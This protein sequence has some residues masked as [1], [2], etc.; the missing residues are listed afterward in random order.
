M[1]VDDEVMAV[2]AID[3]ANPNEG[4]EEER[5]QNNLRYGQLNRFGSCEIN[6]T[7][8][9]EKSH[10]I[11]DRKHGSHDRETFHCVQ[12]FSCIF[13]VSVSFQLEVNGVLGDPDLLGAISH[14]FEYVLRLGINPLT[15][16]LHFHSNLL[17]A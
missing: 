5:E 14:L 17:N 3:T 2:R 6:G 13:L 11:S 10:N 12:P 8:L 4:T 9:E 1:L 16:I 15:S 7:E